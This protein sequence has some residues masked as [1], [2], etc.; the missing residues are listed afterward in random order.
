MNVGNYTAMRESLFLE[1]AATKVS[2]LMLEYSFG[3][4]QPVRLRHRL[5]DRAFMFHEATPST[6]FIASQLLGT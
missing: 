4:Y 1:R 6:M 5:L 2:R 3:D